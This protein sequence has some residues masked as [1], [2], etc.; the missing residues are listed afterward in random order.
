MALTPSLLRLNVDTLTVEAESRP[1]FG[2]FVGYSV[3]SA[4]FV[5]GG[6]LDFSIATRT[7]LEEEVLTFDL[8]V[9]DLKGRAGYAVDNI[10]LYG[11]AGLSRIYIGAG[12][13]NGINFGVGAAYDLGNNVVIGAEYLARRTTLEDD[14]DVDVHLDTLSLRAAYRF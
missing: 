3:K 13:A 6:E 10:L 8:D 11:V 5:F 12:R 2:T 4:D 9:F 7:R 1:A 14:Q